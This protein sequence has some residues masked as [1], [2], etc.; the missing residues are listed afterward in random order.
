MNKF[1]SQGFGQ[2]LTEHM[3]KEAISPTVRKYLPSTVSRGRD[4]VVKATA[5]APKKKRAGIVEGLI[6]R[7]RR[8]R[9]LPS[10]I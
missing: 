5:K 3:Q 7:S 4:A 8:R 1:S 9:F 6:D 2:R 10:G